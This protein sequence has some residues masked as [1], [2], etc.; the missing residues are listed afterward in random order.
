MTPKVY[1]KKVQKKDATKK[2]YLEDILCLIEGYQGYD[3]EYAE[4]Y[5]NK[6]FSDDEITIKD[7]VYIA[8]HNKKVVGVIGFARDYFSTDHSY[9]LGWFVVREDMQGKKVGR[10]L[11]KKVES[12]LIKLGKKKIFVSTEDTNTKAK[13]FYVANGFRTEGVLR[14]Y[15]DEGEDQLILSKELP[16]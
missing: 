11:Y 8:L 7:E 10:R 15:Y 12:D 5:Y 14:D 9:W 2:K 4:R 13:K 6:Y 1:I 3:R 16:H